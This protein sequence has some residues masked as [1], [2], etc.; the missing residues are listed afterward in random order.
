MYSRQLYVFIVLFS[1]FVVSNAGCGSGTPC[2]YLGKQE[3]WIEYAPTAKA[4]ALYPPVSD[5][6]NRSDSS[7]FVTMASFRDKLC[8]VT[9]FNI[10]TK[11]SYPERVT[12]GVV[13]QNMDTD[14]DCFDE[15]CRKM[16]EREAQDHPEIAAS[17]DWKCPF[18][19]QIR[20]KRVSATIAKGPTWGRSQGSE[21]LRDEE[22]CM[23]TDSHMDYTPGWDVSMMK[24]W[25]QTNNEYAVLS[26]YV[27]D[28]AELHRQIDHPHA[29]ALG[30]NKLHEVPLLCM[31]TFTSSHKMVRNWGTKCMRMMPEPKLT[32]IVWGAGLSFAKCHAE[33]KVPYDPHTPHIFDG[34][35]YNRGLRFWTHGYDIYTPNRVYVVHNYQGSQVRWSAMFLPCRVCSCCFLTIHVCLFIHRGTPSTVAGSVICR[36]TQRELLPNLLCG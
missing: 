30:T 8:P 3:G 1:L 17:S 10:F 2:I 26:T 31:V 29:P 25:A 35:E 16:R 22:F 20:M 13:Q 14:I 24:M 7:L 4:K 36:I 27:A 6:W 33:R 28:I 9:L 21:L 11:A 15:Y 12:V 34:E 23:Q 19:N 32:N 5:S 18:E